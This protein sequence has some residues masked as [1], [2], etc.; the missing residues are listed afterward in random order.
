MST[1]ANAE[2]G[3]PEI[4]VTV[5]GGYLGAG[6]TTLVN[7][8]LR[9]ADERIAVL[10]NDFGAVNIDESLIATADD[11]KITLENGCICCSLADGLA[12]ALGQIRTLSPRPE[13]LVI[14]ASGVGN[15]ASIAAN[16]HGNGL[17][18]ECC[19]TVI[20]AETVQAKARDRFVG[21]VVLQQ[22]RCAD[23]LVLNKTDLTDAKQVDSVRSWLTCIAPGIP[24]LSAE[25]GT[26]WL[27]ALLGFDSG[28][29]S[30][31]RNSS[32]P[33]TVEL[34]P[35]DELFASWNVVVDEAFNVAVLTEALQELPSWVIRVKGIVRSPESRRV[36]VHRVGAR[37]EV[38]DIGRC[39]DAPSKLVAIALRNEAG[40]TNPLETLVARS[41]G[42]RAFQQGEPCIRRYI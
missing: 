28:D 5:I 22:I 29:H 9:N 26:V 27:P 24:V 16:A 40:D 37:V 11:H 12:V 42:E 36:V 39:S 35:A 17:R 32:P 3:H 38:R 25:R 15:P 6:K 14:E 31:R 19:I 2:F 30:R 23:L 34:L 41:I 13:R 21:D 7:H 20:D 10:V 4:A 1:T 33:S 18:V 8:I